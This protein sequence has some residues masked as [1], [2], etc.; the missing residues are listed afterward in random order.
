MQGGIGLSKTREF[1]LAA[2]GWLILGAQNPATSVKHEQGGAQSAIAQ[3]LDRIATAYDEQAK[4]SDRPGLTAGAFLYVVDSRLPIRSS[5]ASTE[6]EKQNGK[7]IRW[8]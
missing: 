2:V 4:R 3:S 8:W 1:V 6:E 5:V 7:I